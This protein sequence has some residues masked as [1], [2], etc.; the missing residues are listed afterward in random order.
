MRF[1]LSDIFSLLCGIAGWYY[2]F[3]SQAAARLAHLEHP[4]ANQRRRRLRRICGGTMFLLG[5]A[6]FIGMHLEELGGS[7]KAYI[8]IWLFVLL[9]LLLVIFLAYADIRLTIRL[10]HGGYKEDQP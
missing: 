10:R 2:L 3:Y 6:F 1:A 4:A 8:A 9:L 5:A 7:I